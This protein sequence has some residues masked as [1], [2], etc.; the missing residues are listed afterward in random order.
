M[1]EV[2]RVE[3]VGTPELEAWSKQMHERLE[4]LT[5]EGYKHTYTQGLVHSVQAR[6]LKPSKLC[7]LTMEEEQSRVQLGWSLWDRKM[8][9]AGCAGQKELEKYVASAGAF[10]AHRAE[11]VVG[12]SDQIPVWVKIG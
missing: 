5:G 9:I 12:M 3:G 1:E 7:I 2:S 8:W 4:K 6:L 11:C 10:I